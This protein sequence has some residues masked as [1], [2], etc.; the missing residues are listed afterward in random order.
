M[1]IW[2]RLNLRISWSSRCRRASTLSYSS[3][4]NSLENVVDAHWWGVSVWWLS[5]C[6]INRF[7]VL[8][9]CRVIL[10][11]L[12]VSMTLL[13]WILS[14]MSLVLIYS[15]QIK[16]FLYNS[17]ILKSSGLIWSNW[18]LHRIIHNYILNLSFDLTFRV[19][20]LKAYLSWWLRLIIWFITLISSFLVHVSS[21]AVNIA[22][23][24]NPVIL[25]RSIYL[26]GI[27]RWLFWIMLIGLLLAIYLSMY[28][29]NVSHGIISMGWVKTIFRLVIT[30]F[31]A[32]VLSLEI[33]IW[34]VH[35]HR[36][37]H[38]LASVI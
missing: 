18:R 5:L 37:Y 30:S 2:L 14:T 28:I 34:V 3:R 31:L 35:W 21:G 16:F 17:W 36:V 12:F 13:I 38:V 11:V 24:W 8:N 29:C 26:L 15:T 33:W 7:K 23:L 27:N 6:S 22:R 19:A 1:S 32:I 4:S 25:M 20:E 10:R 9:N